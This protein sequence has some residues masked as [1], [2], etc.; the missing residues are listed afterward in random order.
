M[1]INRIGNCFDK[2][3]RNLVTQS[4]VLSSIYYCIQLWGST[5]DTLLCKAQKIQNFADKVAV[6]GARK[7]DHVSPFIKELKWLKI[8]EKYTFDICTTV[9]KILRRFYPEGFLSFRSVNDV[10]NSVTR[11]KVYM[12][13]EPEQIE[14]AG[15]S[16]CWLPSCGMN[17]Q[18]PSPRLK[19]STRLR[20]T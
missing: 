11:Q 5:N 14:V 16:L 19:T 9:Y 13:P 1:Y 18:P 7:Y 2:P 3:T 12:F 17:S 10:T 6:G 4:H 15:L 8:K 20:L